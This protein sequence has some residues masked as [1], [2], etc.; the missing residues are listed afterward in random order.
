MPVKLDLVGKNDIAVFGKSINL[1]RITYHVREDLSNLLLLEKAV[2]INSGTMNLQG[3]KKVGDLFSKEFVCILF[4]E[5]HMSGLDDGVLRMF[6]DE[7]F[8][9]YD[10]DRSGALDVN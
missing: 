9:M 2:N 8:D 4:I 6:I 7:A 3:G 1:E 10:S 5:L